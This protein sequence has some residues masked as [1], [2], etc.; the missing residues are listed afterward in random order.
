MGDWRARAEITAD[1][2][3]FRY[4][5]DPLERE[6]E[7]VFVWDLDKTYLDTRFESL[8]GLWRTAVEKAFQ[9]KNVPGTASLV[10]ALRNHWQERKRDKRDF[11]IYFITAS[12]PQLEKRIHEKL[13]LDGIYP[14]GIFFKDNLKNLSFS[15]WRRLTQQVGY[16]IQAL[17]QLRLHLKENVRQ[18][19]W[20]DDSEADEV[21]YSLYSDLCARRFSEKDARYILK[22]L[23]VT[24][25]QVDVIFRLLESIPENDPVE[26]VYINLATDTDAEYYVKFGRRVVATSNS[27]QIAVDLFQDHR[28]SQVQVIQV[29]RDLIQNY[30]FTLDEVEISLD[31]LSR[32]RV[33]S[34]QTAD[35]LI[36]LLKDSEVISKTFEFSM[37]PRPVV[38]EVEGRVYELQGVSEPWVADF[39]DYLHEDR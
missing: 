33:L 13:N 24:G 36:P 14:F 5:S 21:I 20:G 28:L 12:P 38:S 26:K 19:L 9:K 1:V 10:R 25:P 32:R 30:E 27:F 18:V 29:A 37:A 11:P 35:I 4:V 23:N 17:L 39:I 34:K 16:K 7:E 2:V 31:D 8:Q 22:T 6:V 15:R 3:L